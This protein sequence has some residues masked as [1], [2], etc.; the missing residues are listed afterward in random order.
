MIAK[1]NR[2]TQRRLTSRPR[3]LLRLNYECI[4]QS[5]LGVYSCPLGSNTPRYFSILGRAIYREHG[6]HFFY[7]IPHL[8]GYTSEVYPISTTSIITTIAIPNT[9]VSDTAKLNSAIQ[10]STIGQRVFDDGCMV[11]PPLHPWKDNPTWRH[12][13]WYQIEEWMRGE[14]S[15]FPKVWAEILSKI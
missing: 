11:Y 2:H 6:Y 10:P 13:E 14:R 8:C 3:V 15:D 1:M 7:S 9:L 12:P 4:R 5:K